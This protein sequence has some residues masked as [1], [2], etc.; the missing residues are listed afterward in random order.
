MRLRPTEIGKGLKITA[1]VPKEEIV[2]TA[3]TPKYSSAHWRMSLFTV[4]TLKPGKRR[5]VQYL[6]TLEYFMVKKN[7]AWLFYAHRI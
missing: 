1:S 7:L 2:M 5:W 3:H 6:N 4:L